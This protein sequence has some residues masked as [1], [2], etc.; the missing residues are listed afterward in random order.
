MSLDQINIKNIVVVGDGT[1]GKTSLLY[2]FH[3]DDFDD[4]YH[5]TV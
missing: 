3:N 2:R 5:T 4:E 1:V